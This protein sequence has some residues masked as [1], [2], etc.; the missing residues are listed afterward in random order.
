MCGC[1]CGVGECNCVVGVPGRTNLPPVRPNRV[2]LPTRLQE[3]DELLVGMVA[4]L[5]SSEGSKTYPL[6]HAQKLPGQKGVTYRDRYV[7][8]WE[9]LCDQL[10]NTEEENVPTKEA[11]TMLR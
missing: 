8:F 10:Q 11:I 1:E 2:T 3:L 9:K 7:L 6:T 4:A 5:T